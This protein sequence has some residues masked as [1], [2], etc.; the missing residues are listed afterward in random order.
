MAPH[1]PNSAAFLWGRD[2]WYQ[3]RI[4]PYGGKRSDSASRHPSRKVPS[5]ILLRGD[6][7]FA[8]AEPR[9]YWIG[10]QYSCSGT[11]CAEVH[12]LTGHM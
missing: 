2:K 11:V 7:F 9:Y 5:G 10:N 1:G 4:A 12:V 3:S 8:S 6:I